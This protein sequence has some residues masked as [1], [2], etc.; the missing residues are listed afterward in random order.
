MWKFER[1]SDSILSESEFILVC[2]KWKGLGCDISFQSFTFFKQNLC[3]QL[4]LCITMVN[5]Q[6]W[7]QGHSCLEINW[8]L[9]H[10]LIIH[11]LYISFSFSQRFH[12]L[13][14]D[15]KSV[16]FLCW[17]RL[18]TSWK[19]NNFCQIMYMKCRDEKRKN[20]NKMNEIIRKYYDNKY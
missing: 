10:L 4:F 17:L 8:N 5:L 14:Y 15:A 11:I 3:K 12:H 7:T 9:L 19:L 1:Y 13:E 20:D 2:L 6:L 18:G 16:D